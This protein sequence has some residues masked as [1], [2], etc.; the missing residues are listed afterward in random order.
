MNFSDQKF[1][2]LNNLAPPRC[3]PNPGR[4]WFGSSAAWN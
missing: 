1:D 3:F 4:A 2:Q